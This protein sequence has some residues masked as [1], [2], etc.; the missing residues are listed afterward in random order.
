M[1]HIVTGPHEYSQAPK[2]AYPGSQS[3]A[4]TDPIRSAQRAKEVA[5]AQLM[6]AHEHGSLRI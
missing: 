2:G 3:T 5:V 4:Y 1:P 6:P